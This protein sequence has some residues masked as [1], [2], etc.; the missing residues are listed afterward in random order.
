MVRLFAVRSVSA[1]VLVLGFGL[2]TSVAG[3]T[4]FSQVVAFGDSLSDNGNLQDLV[5]VPAAPYW[6]GRFSNGAVAVEVLAAGLATTLDDRAYGGATSG[7]Y[8]G[9]S[10]YVG[11]AYTGDLFNLTG[12]K[13]GLR[14]QV[15]SYLGLDKNT[16]GVDSSALYVVWAGANDFEYLGA[17]EAVAVQTIT[18]LVTSVAKLYGAGARNFLLPNLPDLGITPLALGLNEVIPG[19]SAAASGL[20][21][22]FNVRLGQAYTGLQWTLNDPM[23]S[24]ISFDVMARQ[25]AVAFNPAAFDFSNVTTPCYAGEPGGAELSLCPDATGYFYFDR[26]HPT[27]AAHALLG[28]Q[29][30]A[31]VPEPAS[32]LLMAVG[33]LGLLGLSARRRQRAS[34][35]PQH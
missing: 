29:M 10:D 22:M 21:E 34:A 18:N 6:N 12:V 9:P 1:A 28:S 31:A 16:N 17:T 3:A 27:A 35:A 5:G 7:Y 11:G 32:M 15:D 20:S 14:G 2:A 33:T 24:L 8:H 25:R 4:T 19:Y 23:L 13:T 30:L 26:L